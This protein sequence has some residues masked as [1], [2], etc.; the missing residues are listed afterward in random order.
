MTCGVY[1]SLICEN[2]AMVPALQGTGMDVRFLEALDGHNWE[3]WRDCLGL[4]I[5]WLFDGAH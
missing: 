5:P 4:A 1:E 2:R 3:S